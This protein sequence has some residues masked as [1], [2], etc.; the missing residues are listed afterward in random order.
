MTSILDF[1]FPKSC[2]GCGKSGVYLCQNCLA[3]VDR[4]K[5]ICPVCEKP[6]PFGTTHSYCQT[7][8]S[9]DGLV[10]FF[11]YQKIIR[12]AIH[13]L[14]YR[15]ATALIDEIAKAILNEINNRYK[16]TYILFIN[17]LK[18][19]KP[20]ILP[21]PLY[22]YKQNKRGFNQASLLGEVVSKQFNLPFND[23]ILT[24]KKSN[25][26]QTELSMKEREQNVKNIFSVHTSH[27]PPSLLLIDDVWTTGSTMKEACRVLKEAG[28][29]KVWGMTIA[30]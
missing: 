24:R 21:I 6:Q 13:K 23:K 15:Y 11:G 1:L 27:V 28:V 16:D 17:Q 19:D 2:L 9:L 22:W 3:K 26:S 4:P 30:R 20:V 10:Y 12:E 5:L 29:G 25:T 8:Y 14:K 7:K 18:N